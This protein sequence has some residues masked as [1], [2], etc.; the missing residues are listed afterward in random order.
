MSWRRGR[1]QQ[2]RRARMP[3]TL[4]SGMRWDFK[5][6]DHIFHVSR[7]WTGERLKYTC[8]RRNQ[9]LKP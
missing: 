4:Y 1:E 9:K 5:A 2:G 6:G 3:L 8:D 7:E